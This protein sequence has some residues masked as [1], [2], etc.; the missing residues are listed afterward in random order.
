MDQN[1][2]RHD[3]DNSDLD[4]DAGTKEINITLFNKIPTDLPGIDLET[5]NSGTSVV[6]PKID[7]SNAEHINEETT[8]IVLIPGG[9]IS[10]STEVDTLIYETPL[11]GAIPLMFH[12]SVYHLK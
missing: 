8:N 11:G 4:E 10:R 5:Y 7:Q 1:K 3:C 12:R 6:T 2:E 9:N